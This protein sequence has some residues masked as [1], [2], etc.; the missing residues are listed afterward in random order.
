MSAIRVE[1]CRVDGDGRATLVVVSLPLG[2]SVQEAVL[3]SGL[4]A[5]S[6][7]SPEGLSL[8]IS[9]RRVAEHR[10]LSDGD[11]VELLPPVLIDPKLARARRVAA[12]ELAG[13]P[14]S[15]KL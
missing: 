10:P 13:K 9:G 6:A 15:R 2:A 3:A 4:M 8:A 12:R 7:G 14:G 5:G 11:R 1:V